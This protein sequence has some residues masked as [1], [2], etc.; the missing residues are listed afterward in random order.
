MIRPYHPYLQLSVFQDRRKIFPADQALKMAA[1]K[2]GLK[3]MID[4]YRM[5]LSGISTFTVHY[6]GIN[7]K[8]S[9]ARTEYVAFNV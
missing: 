1:Q 5:H 3:N 9:P 4:F 6:I 8:P 2:N 7:E